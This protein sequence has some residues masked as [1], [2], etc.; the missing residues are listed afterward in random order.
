MIRATQSGLPVLAPEM[1]LL[2]KAKNCAD[3]D[4]ADFDQIMPHLS[5]YAREWL[6]RALEQAHPSCPW[7]SSLTKP[8]AS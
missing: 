1:V 2:F 5:A 7:I 3:K 4:R 8:P 6:R